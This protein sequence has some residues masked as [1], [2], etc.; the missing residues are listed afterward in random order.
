MTVKRSFLQPFALILGLL[1]AFVFAAQTAQAA[2]PAK[3]EYNFYDEQNMLSDKTKKLI[4]DRNLYYDK[5]KAKPQ[6]M[7]AV[8]ESTGGDS[9]DSYAPELFHKWGIGQSGK[10]NGILILF[11]VNDGDNNVRIEVG[12]GLED[13]ITDSIAG[14]ILNK[15]RADLK[16]NDRTTINKGLRGTF[17]SVASIIDDHYGYK[18]NKSNLSATEVRN[19]K[20]KADDG[21]QTNNWPILGFIIIVMFALFIVFKDSGGGGSSGP[22]NHSDGGGFPWWL[23]GSGGSGS[24]G[25]FGGSG[26]DSGGFGGFSGGGGDSGGGGSSI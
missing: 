3:P 20:Q 2:L 15:N 5:T 9:I 17:N 4:S 13:V 12:Y 8:I 1:M 23:G 18:G 10:D 21:E 24:S 7:L 14:R 19:L 11:A 26:G 25:G 22:G 6:I 16:S